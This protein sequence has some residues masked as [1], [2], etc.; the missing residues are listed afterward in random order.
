[1]FRFFR[2]LL[3]A[4]LGLTLA[5]QPVGGKA[6][7]YGSGSGSG[8]T[9]ASGLTYQAAGSGSVSTTQAE[10]NARVVHV[11]DYMTAGDRA[12]LAAGTLSSDVTYAFTAAINRA[13]ALG[14]GT[15]QYGPGKHPC[16]IVLNKNGITLKGPGMGPTSLAPSSYLTPYTASS[17][18]IQIGDGTALTQGVSVQDVTLYAGGSGQK[19]LV[20]AGG[21]YKC[22]VERLTALSFTVSCIEA[23]NNDVQPCSFNHLNGIH[24]QTNVAGAAAIRLLD[25]HV[26]GT[27]WTTAIEISNFSA[28]APN[29]Y[30]I[31]CDG[32]AGSLSNGYLQCSYSGLGIWMGKSAT[33]NPS[34]NLHNVEIDSMS[35]APTGFPYVAVVYDGGVDPLGTGWANVVPFNGSLKT[36]GSLLGLAGHTTGTMSASSTTLTVASATNLRPGR[37]VWV[38][39]AGA[40]ARPLIATIAAVSGTTITLDTA[41]TTA[42]SGVDVGYGSIIGMD[43]P[44]PQVTGLA[45][46]G[47]LWQ[48]SVRKY[49][50]LGPRNVTYRASGNGAIEPSNGYGIVH[51][52]AYSVPEFFL[53]PVSAAV[54]PSSITQST[55]TITITT[56]G[57]HYAGVGDLVVISGCNEAGVNGEY[58]VTAYTSATVFTVTSGTSQTLAGVTGSPQVQ[59]FKVHAFRNGRFELAGGIAGGLGVRNNAGTVNSIL[60]SDTANAGLRMQ[61]PDTTNGFGSFNWGSGITTGVGFAWGNSGAN[62]ARLTGNGVFMLAETSA[63]SLSS[64][65]G[66]IYATSSDHQVYAMNAGGTGT[67]LTLDKTITAAGTTGA[68]TINKPLGTVRFA[69]AGTSLVV[70]NSLVTTSSIILATV[71]T[72]DSTMKSVQAVPAAGSFTLYANAAATAET[73]VGWEVKN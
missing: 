20:L 12:A 69:V 61:T 65:W 24:A 36:N 54:T 49:T 67:L 35:G 70:T 56:S 46:P 71:M 34:L 16:N 43:L 62:K 23:T 15:V 11:L 63:P 4:L 68:Q 25:P 30:Q 10:I 66:Q 1:M 22:N 41:A 5:A 29:G 55:T 19:G 18:T 9:V 39:G 42:V 21:A 6:S 72:N 47:I 32:A 13:Y 26:A 38:A 33:Y 53:Q 51:D 40:S 60:Y 37:Q 52:T 58:L 50:Y 64:G 31:Y 14:G 59:V 57:S 44:S 2:V 73:V 7:P 3:A 28:T 17:P 45:A 27:G 48:P 8:T